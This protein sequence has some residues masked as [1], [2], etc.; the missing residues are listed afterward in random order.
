VAFLDHDDE[1]APEA[2]AEVARFITA[3][4]EVDVVYSD[5]DKLDE[6]GQR[7]DPHFKPDWSPDLFLSY[8]YSCH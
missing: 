4:P 8:M 6:R 5:E 2:L 1:L 3:N 7:C